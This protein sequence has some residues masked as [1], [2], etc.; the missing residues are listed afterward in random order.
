[1][2]EET[3]R[4]VLDFTEFLLARLEDDDL[5]AWRQGVLYSA[6]RRYSDDEPDYS[7]ADLKSE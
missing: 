6:A 2:P 5:A 4:E 1:M 7:L 3:A